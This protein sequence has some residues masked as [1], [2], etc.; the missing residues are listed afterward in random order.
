MAALLR[1]GGGR[2]LNVPCGV[3]LPSS[4][5][6]IDPWPWW[7]EMGQCWSSRVDLAHLLA[8]GHV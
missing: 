3:A 2:L 8:E 6:G 7:L 1:E 5:M 4:P